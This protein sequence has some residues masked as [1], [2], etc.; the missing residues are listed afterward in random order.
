MRNPFAEDHDPKLVDAVVIQAEH[1]EEWVF[2]AHSHD[3]CTE[4]SFLAEGESEVRME[5]G[6]YRLQK[7][8][9]LIK[10]Q[11]VI[12]QEKGISEGPITLICLMINGVHFEGD[13]PEEILDQPKHAQLISSDRCDLLKELFFY[14]ERSVKKGHVSQETLSALLLI[15]REVELEG[16]VRLPKSY[17]KADFVESIKN[18][19]DENYAEKLSL[20]SLSEQFFISPYYMERIF[21]KEIGNNINRYI[22][23]RRM[24]EAERSLIFTNDDIKSIANRCG[25]TDIHYFYKV[26]KKNTGMT[27]AEFRTVMRKV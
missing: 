24:G 7:G 18:Y 1:G 9:V 8:D 12:H 25:F 20:K 23:D 17:V 16:L 26:F 11:Q 10:R 14:L 22:I 5:D 13:E 3:S 21:T 4:V 27:P 2:P 15:L 19:I 6:I